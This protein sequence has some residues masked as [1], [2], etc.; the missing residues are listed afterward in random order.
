MKLTPRDE[1]PRTSRGF[2][3]AW[4]EMQLAHVNIKTQFV[5]CITTLSIWMGEGR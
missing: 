4:L 3:T 1:P 5:G 2:N